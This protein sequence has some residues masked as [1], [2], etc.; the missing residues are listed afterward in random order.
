M[1][2]ARPPRYVR[3]ITFW[4]PLKLD[5]KIGVLYKDESIKYYS[6]I[7]KGCLVEDSIDK[8]NWVQ[9]NAIVDIVIAIDKINFIQKINMENVRKVVKA[10]LSINANEGIDTEMLKSYAG[11]S[12]KKAKTVI[13][14]LISKT[15]NIPESSLNEV[16]DVI[17]PNSFVNIKKMEDGDLSQ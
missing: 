13:D 2:S 15:T 12:G 8:T 16:D 10:N 9:V 4:N 17:N 5:V 1:T 14:D 7:Y 6:C 11:N 3:S